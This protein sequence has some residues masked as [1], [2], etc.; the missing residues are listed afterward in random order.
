MKK[1]LLVMALSMLASTATAMPVFST[2]LL[3]DLGY[4]TFF[5]DDL[6]GVSTN[7]LFE[8]KLEEAGQANSNSFG[9][10]QRNDGAGVGTLGVASSIEL[11][12]GADSVNEVAKLSW[13]LLDNSLTLFKST[14][15][16]TFNEVFL[17]ALAIDHTGFGFYLD[18]IGGTFFSETALNADGVDHMVAL[19]AGAVDSFILAW[20]DLPGG[21][22]GDYND[23]VLLADDINP[24]AVPAPNPMSL[25]LLGLGMVGM[26]RIVGKSQRDQRYNRK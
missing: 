25:M 8:I 3:D 12:S 24:Q 2:S 18:T 7:S 22:D 21:G 20:E 23:F 6:G 19:Q 26:A 9:L 5:L 16:I 14:N 13:N 1:L 17:G 10:Y 4:E 15:G 11:F